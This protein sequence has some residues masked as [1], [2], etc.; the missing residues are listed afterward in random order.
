MG[1]TPWRAGGKTPNEGV[2]LG[3]MKNSRL[4]PLLTNNYK[5]TETGK[6]TTQSSISR[7]GKGPHKSAVSSTS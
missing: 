6:M 7:K 5:E 3:E 2:R 1:G 4:R